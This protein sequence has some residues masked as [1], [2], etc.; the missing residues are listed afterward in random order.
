MKLLANHLINPA[1][2]VDQLPVMGAASDVD[3][4]GLPNVI[5][6]ENNHKR[7]RFLVL[8]FHQTKRT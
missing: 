2:K 3:H 1:K 4:P 5:S 7:R 6:W 8:S